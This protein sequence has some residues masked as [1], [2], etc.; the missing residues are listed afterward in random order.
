MWTKELPWWARV[1]PLA[2]VLGVVLA[3]HER[4]PAPTDAQLA[5]ACHGPPLRTAQAREQAM[6]D[7]HRINP[8]YDCID[9]V[10]WL[11][12][13]RE[14]ARQREEAAHPR[15]QVA[16]PAPAP[17]AEEAAMA[18]SMAALREESARARRFGGVA[19]AFQNRRWA[20]ARA[21]SLPLA[22]EGDARSQLILGELLHKGLGGE[23]DDVAAHEWLRKSAAQGEPH[24][25]ALLERWPD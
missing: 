7:G 15:P 11:E 25:A 18:A 24:A 1:L 9:Q 2:L 3:V 17:T 10:A 14:L 8:R 13:Q 16:A 21:L 20:L 22:N 5:A 12:E 4:K 6:I 23:R 19:A